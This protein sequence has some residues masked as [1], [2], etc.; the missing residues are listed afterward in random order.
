[1]L[2]STKYSRCYRQ[3]SVSFCNGKASDK[4][5]P[6]P[7]W[8]LAHETDLPT[9]TKVP[10]ALAKHLEQLSLVNFEDTSAV[11]RLESAIRFADQILLVDTDGVE[12]MEFPLEN[13]SLHLRDD[14]PCETNQKI[15]K[16]ADVTFEDYYVAPVGNIQYE[17]EAIPE[18]DVKKKTEDN[19]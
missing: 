11:V 12:P 8:N 16:L 9:P 18:A 19:T 2:R 14:V 1:M 3:F 10:L 7:V 4:I 15:V 13:I 5:P 17:G 6:M